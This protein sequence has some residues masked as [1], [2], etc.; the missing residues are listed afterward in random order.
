MAMLYSEPKTINRLM[1]DRAFA[2]QCFIGTLQPACQLPGIFTLVGVLSKQCGDSPLN[3]LQP[4]GM[5]V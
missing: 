4:N 2:N 5:A 1:V 3:F